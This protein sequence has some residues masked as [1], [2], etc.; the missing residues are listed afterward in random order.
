MKLITTKIKALLIISKQTFNY[1]MQLNGCFKLQATKNI[2]KHK[3]S[4]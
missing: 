3:D 2:K 4:V 1:K